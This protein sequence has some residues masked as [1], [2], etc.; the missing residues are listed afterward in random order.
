MFS[1]RSIYFDDPPQLG[2]A[3]DIWLPKRELPR[4][5][6]LFFV[7]GGGW[8][9]GRRDDMHG[10]MHAFCEKGFVC[11]SV[12]YRVQDVPASVQMADVREGLLLADGELRRQGIDQPF[13]L[14]GSSAGGHL[15][16]LT[17]LA[18]PGVCG[19]DAT[20]A[21]PPIAGIIASCAP[22]TFEPWADIFP[23]SW[24]SIQDVVGEPWSDKP[25]CYRRLSPATYVNPG[26]PPL[27]FLLGECEH[28]FP[29][30][31]TMSLVERVNAMG[32]DAR[33]KVYPAAEHGFFYAVCR[34]SQE[35]AFQ[36][37]L[38]FLA[39]VSEPDGCGGSAPSA[40][41]P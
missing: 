21:M 30:E 12:D 7:H 23:G 14:Y 1:Y 4:P 31:L 17:G 19:D 11:V 37:V 13:V 39:D 8:R 24:D 18:A 25:E 34:R 27:F 6:T 3:L 28:M 36:D 40:I 22:V 5:V 2:R 15:A 41:H 26:S 38:A 33:Y 16:L 29:N 10:L 20:T 32:G 35:M 9:Q